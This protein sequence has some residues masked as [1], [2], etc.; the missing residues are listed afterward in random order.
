MTNVGV[1]SNRKFKM[2]TTSHT[3]TKNKTFKLELTTAVID[4][5][6][7][8]VSGNFNDWSTHNERF[9]MKRLARGRY[10][11]TFP[12]DM[13]LPDTLE[14]K[15]NKGG[16]DQVELNDEGNSPD[17]RTVDHRKEKIVRDYVP[18]WRRDG[19]STHEDLMP[20]IELLSENYDV[21]QLATDRRIQVLLPHDYYENLDTRYPVLYLTDAQNLF[22]AGSSYGNWNIDRKLA[23]LAARDHAGV[24]IVAIDHGNEERIREFSPYDMPRHGKGRGKDFL[25]FITTTLKKEIDQKYRT[26]SDRLHTGIGGS[27]LGGLLAAYAGLMHPDVFSKLMVFSPSLW[28]SPR[29]YF[30][31][32][33]FFEPFATR[34]YFYGGNREGANMVKNLE[35]LYETLEKQG[36]GFDRVQ[37]QLEIDPFG[38]HHESRWGE[39]FPRAL[40][41]L[42]Y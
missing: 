18:H 14:Y 26:L 32:V 22:G 8:Y 28:L 30:D 24:I 16:W 7:V 1:G 33:H 9:E 38:K 20:I 29:I 11:Y 6:P 3:K 17:N 19:I 12:A 10:E 40:E 15:Y 21:P 13:P 36:Y 4:D 25:K 42:Y 34:M 23:V 37:L 27:S 2:S 31:A 41:W 35:Y 5:R 39:E